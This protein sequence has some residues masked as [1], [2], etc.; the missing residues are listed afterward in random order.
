MLVTI[1]ILWRTLIGVN[2]IQCV[3]LPE[4]RFPEFW[5]LFTATVWKIIK[6]VYGTFE[7][8]D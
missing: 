8:V 4:N 1:H 7:I 5:I 6:F 2:W 3:D